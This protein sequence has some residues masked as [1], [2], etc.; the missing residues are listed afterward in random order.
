MTAGKKTAK[1]IVL[2]TLRKHKKPMTPKQIQALTKLNYNTI[3]GRLQ[4]L[5]KE[6]LIVRT[7]EGWIAKEHVEQ[8]KK[9]KKT[10][11][12]RRTKKAKK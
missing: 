10:K 11:K 2:E 6:G 4:D 9:T 7:D 12:T 8:V 3:R 5:K 1:E